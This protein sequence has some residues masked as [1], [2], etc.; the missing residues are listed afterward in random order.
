MVGETR[1]DTKRK[2]WHD[3]FKA[4]AGLTAIIAGLSYL[5][6]GDPTAGILWTAALL[7][8]ASK[9]KYKWQ[10]QVQVDGW[11]LV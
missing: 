3:T 5:G 9:I 2:W 11:K 7:F 6:G 8:V 4:C 1:I 10:K